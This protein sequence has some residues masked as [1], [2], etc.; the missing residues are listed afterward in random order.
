MSRYGHS[1]DQKTVR[2]WLKEG[3]DLLPVNP[4]KD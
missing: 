1:V 2:G 4:Q 3:A